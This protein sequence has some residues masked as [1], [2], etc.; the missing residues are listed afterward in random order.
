MRLELGEKT[1]TC[2]TGLAHYGTTP[3]LAT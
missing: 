3:Y 1:A 2:R